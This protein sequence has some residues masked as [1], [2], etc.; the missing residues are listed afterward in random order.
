[1]ANQ[2]AG[3]IGKPAFIRDPRKWNIKHAPVTAAQTFKVGDWVGKDTNGTLVIVAAASNDWDG[4]TPAKIW[5]IAMANAVD[6]LA[7]PSG[8]LQQCPVMVP[9][10]DAEF[11]SQ[12]YHATPASAV[13]ADSA[14][15]APTTLPLRNQGGVWVLSLA[16][17][18]TNDVCQI[19]SRY[20]G[21]S[22]TDQYPWCWCKLLSS[23][24][25]EGD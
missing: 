21:H 3:N 12:I 20:I 4:S 19:T 8:D 5:G 14:L 25:L 16:N 15:D 1:M 9:G 6:V 10:R 18:G 22:G 23:V 13:I 7:A 11:L 2:T 17:D 24:S